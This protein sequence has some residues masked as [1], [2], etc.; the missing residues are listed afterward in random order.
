MYICVYITFASSFTEKRE[1]REKVV[2]GHRFYRKR[3]EDEKVEAERWSPRWWWRLPSLSLPSP[4][5]WK[6]EADDA[7]DGDDGD[8]AVGPLQRVQ[9]RRRRTPTP[10]PRPSPRSAAPTPSSHRLFRRREED[11]GSGNF[12]SDFCKFYA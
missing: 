5:P 11:D 2:S 1:R 4:S 10:P 7:V 9:R 3:R 8:A 6:T 12:R